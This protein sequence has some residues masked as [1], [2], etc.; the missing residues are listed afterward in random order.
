MNG[1]IALDSVKII[2]APSSNKMR[3][4]GSSQNFFLTFINSKNSIRIS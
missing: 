4:M 1:A 3:I 2:N